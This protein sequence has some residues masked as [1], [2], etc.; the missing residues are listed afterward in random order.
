MRTM[1]YILANMSLAVQI[2][3]LSGALLGSFFVLQ[4]IWIL[5]TIPFVII[6]Y[7]LYSDIR[8]IFL[9]LG[10]VSMIGMGYYLNIRIDQYT[11]IQA[12][13]PDRLDNEEMIIQSSPR[14]QSFGYQYKAHIP[15]YN[16]YI[17]ITLNLFLSIVKLFLLLLI[18]IKNTLKHSNS[19]GEML[20]KSILS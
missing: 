18:L 3:L 11:H 13:I 2:G 4:S 7:W 16:A 9:L 12:N 14:I 20:I 8:L 6:I 15:E 5:L 19:S 1:K 10:L 17:F